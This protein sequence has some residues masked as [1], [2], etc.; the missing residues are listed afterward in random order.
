[1]QNQLCMRKRSKRQ[2]GIH[3]F[4]GICVLCAALLVNLTGC[5][6]GFDAAGYSQALLDLTFQADITKAATF[7]KDASREALMQA[8]R[9]SIDRFVAANIT[10]GLEL[11]EVKTTRFAE[12]VSKIFMI[13]RYQ[14]GEAVK[15][16]KREYEVPVKIWPADV[17][18]TFQEMLVE[19]S[20][21]M[22]EKIEG[23]EYDGYSEEEMDQQIL[24]DI[25]N[26]AYELLDTAYMDIQYGEEETVVF[27]VS[28]RKGSEYS[29][30]EDDMDGLIRKIL[31]LD[32]IQS[33]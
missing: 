16:G 26:H 32:E 9:D 20:L 24:T 11:G 18:V 33:M 13:M 7:M 10:S 4:F 6:S 29:V 3:R 14:V 17:F 28:A 19:D 15:T 22:A 2:K 1:M 21:K 31:R 27:H 12:L 25:V 23:G 8:Y 5:G 30:D